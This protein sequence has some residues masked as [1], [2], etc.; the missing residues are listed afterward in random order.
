MNENECL[1]CGII[2][3]RIP[4]KIIFEDDI[5]IGIL[6]I[7]PISKGHT[8]IIPKNHYF[9]IEDIPDDVLS[10]LFVIVKKLGKKIRNQLNID[11]YNILQ[12][13]FPAAGQVINHFHIHII[14][15]QTNDSKFHI[16]IPKSQIDNST[17]EEVK[18]A[19]LG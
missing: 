2:S 16:K 14:P 12:N 10:H 4:A 19:I 1:F 11:G 17:L 5:C 7:F 3:N 15:R 6:D 18:S 13:N 8:L 9:N